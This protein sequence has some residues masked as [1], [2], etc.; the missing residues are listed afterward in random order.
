MANETSIKKSGYPVSSLR[1]K[2]EKILGI[3]TNLTNTTTL[4]L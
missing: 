4:Q 3:K 1:H 2:H